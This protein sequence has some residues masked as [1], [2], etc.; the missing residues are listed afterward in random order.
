[1]PDKRGF[2]VKILPFDRVTVIII[3]CYRQLM[4]EIG[5]GFL[6]KNVPRPEKIRF[7][8]GKNVSSGERPARGGKTGGADASKF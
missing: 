2:F 3:R 6:G 4:Q 7:C 1:M 8:P 5:W